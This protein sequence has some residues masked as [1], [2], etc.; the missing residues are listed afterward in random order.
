MCICMHVCVHLHVPVYVYV[1]ICMYGSG[2]MYPCMFMSVFACMGLGAC[3]RVCLCLYLHVWV[4]VHV[5]VYVYVCICMYGSGCMDAHMC[6]QGS[7][8]SIRRFPH[9]RPT[10]SITSE[11]CVYFSAGLWRVPLCLAP[12]SSSPPASPG[13]RTAA[14]GTAR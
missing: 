13:Q 3:T 10:V 14:A 4:W 2:C 8:Q 12:A 9:S 6:V 5:P 11:C 7:V 1:C